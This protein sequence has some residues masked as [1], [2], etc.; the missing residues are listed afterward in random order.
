MQ[1]NR[2]VGSNSSVKCVAS[3]RNIFHMSIR[4]KCGRDVQ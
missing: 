1:E 3:L 4:R 2:I